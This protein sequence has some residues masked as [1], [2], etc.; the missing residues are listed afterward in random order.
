MPDYDATS[1]NIFSEPENT[2]ILN[3]IIC[4]HFYRIG[5]FDVANE[6]IAVCCTAYTFN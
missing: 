5:L 3:Q 2:V 1:R 6:F 4:R